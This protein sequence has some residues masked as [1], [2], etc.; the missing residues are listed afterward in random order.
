METTLLVG[1]LI[2]LIS[3]AAVLSALFYFLY[4]KKAEALFG[5]WKEKE[6]SRELARSLTAQRSTIKGRIS[7]QLFP[8][9]ARKEGNL[10]D[11]RFLGSPIDYVVFDGLASVNGDSGGQISI[12]FVEIK[13]TK[14]SALT[15]TEKAVRDAVAAKRVS[16]EEIYL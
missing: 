9:L 12:K 16:W 15:Y 13:S 3:A 5:A 14:D 10:S 8:I 1:I 6:M 2:G 7:E 4:R 11:F